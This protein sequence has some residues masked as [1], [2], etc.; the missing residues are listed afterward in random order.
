MSYFM[1]LTDS[2]RWGVGVTLVAAKRNAGYHKRSHNAL[3]LEWD[4]EPSTW[5]I[6]HWGQV[7]WSDAELVAEYFLR[8]PHGK[9]EDVAVDETASA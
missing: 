4:Q 2:Q 7:M 3:V 5:R 9:R 1:V 6:D 8:L